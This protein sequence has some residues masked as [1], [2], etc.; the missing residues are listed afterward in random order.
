MS[1]NDKLFLRALKWACAD[2]SRSVYFPSSLSDSFAGPSIR[3]PLDEVLSQSADAATKARSVYFFQY[4]IEGSVIMTVILDRQ[5]DVQRSLPSVI[6]ALVFQRLLYHIIEQY[7]QRLAA[8][9]RML[10]HLM[11]TQV[12]VQDPQQRSASSLQRGLGRLQRPRSIS[13]FS[14][15]GLSSLT[16]TLFGDHPKAMQPKV[17][18]SVE[19][20]AETPLISTDTL[21]LL[22]KLGANFDWID[23]Q[24]NNALRVFLHHLSRY[25]IEYSSPADHFKKHVALK[26]LSKM[27]RDPADVSPR[28]VTAAATRIKP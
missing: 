15:R 6:E 9:G 3:R 20:L 28:T 26:K 10:T 2:L 16:R 5:K 1:E 7:H 18:V 23:N 11:M 27:F 14:F 24:A 19:I 25:R 4:P 17:A 13:L 21:L 12:L 8:H 22:R